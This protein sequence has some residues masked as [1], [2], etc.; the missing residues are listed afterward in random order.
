MADKSLFIF[1]NDPAKKRKKLGKVKDLMDT[2]WNEMDA[3]WN[4]FEQYL[5]TI[6]KDKN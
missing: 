5:N 3:T 2:D 4:E 1:R 6:T